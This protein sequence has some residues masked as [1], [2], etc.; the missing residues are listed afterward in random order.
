MKKYKVYKHPD[1]RLEA[2]KDGFSFPGLLFAGLWLLWHKMWVVGGVAVIACLA[3]YPIF[4]NPEGYVL[5]IP[6]G[7]KFGIADIL[8]MGFQ[9]IVGLYGNE[10][11]STSLEQRG[12]E[13]VATVRAATP[14]GA[15]AEYLLQ[16]TDPSRPVYNF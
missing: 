6:Y 1:N 5:G 3:V 9:V 8:N 11:R 13:C 2:V 7:H 10:W 4:P 16:N 15:K 12:F 14:D